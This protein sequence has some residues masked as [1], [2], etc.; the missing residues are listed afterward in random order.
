MAPQPTARRHLGPKVVGLAFVV[1]GAVA[2]LAGCNAAGSTTSSAQESATPTQQPRSEATT[3]PPAERT[4]ATGSMQ[5]VAQPAETVELT[6]RVE[7]PEPPNGPAERPEFF[8]AFAPVEGEPE[9]PNGE[10]AP[11]S[12]GS[13]YTSTRLTDEDGDG[14]FG[15]VIEVEVGRYLVG[16]WSSSDVSE[17]S[18]GG[19]GTDQYP[20]EPA[21]LI[22]Q[23]STVRKDATITLESERTIDA[24]L[25]EP[26]R[27]ANRSSDGDQT[28]ASSDQGTPSPSPVSCGRVSFEEGTDYGA[29][30]IEAT[31]TNCETARAVARESKGKLS[32]SPGGPAESYRSL[33]FTCR[34]SGPEGELQT[35]P[36]EC[37]DGEAQITFRRN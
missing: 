37:T 35:Y 23:Q 24:P 4:A 6:F 9:N 30:R 10:I 8:G 1:V 36:Y 7:T 28:S 31:G 25:Y 13:D 5:A 14:V 2:A 19:E 16:V 26:Q 21:E 12:A 11:P 3:A 34:A 27:S 22:S 33:G 32:A 20:A 29:F 18:G 17:G 15:A